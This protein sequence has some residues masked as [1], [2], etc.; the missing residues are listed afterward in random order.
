MPD[1]HNA[2][3]LHVG[4]VDGTCTI[5]VDSIQLTAFAD[6]LTFHPWP[7]PWAV[8]QKELGEDYSR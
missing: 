3:G 2:R 7:Q 4:I 6:Y 8:R 5:K 1:G